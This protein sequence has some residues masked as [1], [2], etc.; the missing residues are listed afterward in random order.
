MSK[1]DDGV[2]YA[3]AC[4]PCFGARSRGH[5]QVGVFVNNGNDVR[6]EPVSVVRIELAVPEFLVIALY[7]ADSGLGDELVTLVHLY[8]Q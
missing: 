2:C 6:E 5:G 1:P 3:P 8:A 7:V 4:C